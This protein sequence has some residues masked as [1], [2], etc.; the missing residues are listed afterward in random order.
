MKAI[1]TLLGTLAL[2][3]SFPSQA[4]FGLGSDSDKST[5]T[6][7]LSAITETLTSQVSSQSESP[8]IGMLTNQLGV[9]PTQATSGAGAMLALASNSLSGDNTSEL[10]QLI[11]GM[12]SLQSSTPGLLSMA[13]NMRAV[14]DV[15]STLGLDPSMIAQ[16]A[17]V[18]L[19][20]LTKQGASSGLLGSLS[21][22][23]QN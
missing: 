12:S 6:S 22:L 17:P 20:Y 10:S 13:T 7:S 8:L 11:P 4:I 1:T 3:I 14:N 9:S 16:F 19:N 5:D 18:I 21:N 2:I 23:W 15:F